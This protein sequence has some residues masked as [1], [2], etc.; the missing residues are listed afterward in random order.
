[1]HNTKLQLQAMKSKSIS[2]PWVKFSKRVRPAKHLFYAK[3]YVKKS[4]KY[5][6]FQNMRAESGDRIV[7]LVGD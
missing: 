4:V 7:L 5:L 3:Y 6:Q 2:F 1:M